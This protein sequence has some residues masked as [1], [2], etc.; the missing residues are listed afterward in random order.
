MTHFT[1]IKSFGTY[2]PRNLMVPS[3]E[4]VFV[5]WAVFRRYTSELYFHMERKNSSI[6]SAIEPDP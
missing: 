4:E 6:F 1:V 2:F 3:E 5:D